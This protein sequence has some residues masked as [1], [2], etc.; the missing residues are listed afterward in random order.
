[1][2]LN[3][4]YEHSRIP[5]KPLPYE[6][7]RLADCNEI[8]IDYSGDNPSYHIYIVDSSDKSKYI[9][10]TALIL[11]ATVGEYIY[12]KLDF[13]LCIWKK[14]KQYKSFIS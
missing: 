6:N 12:I 4:Q 5:L 7:R 3:D 8:M 14:F 11:K 2:S 9:D 13:I 10:I 1:M